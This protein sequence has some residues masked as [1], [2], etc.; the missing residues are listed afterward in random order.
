MSKE[1]SSSLW[2]SFCLVIECLFNP[3]W[4]AIL[5]P[6]KIQ[7]EEIL[8]RAMKYL[9]VAVSFTIGL[10][11]LLFFW[12]FEKKTGN[13]DLART[14]VFATVA[15]VSL[16]YVFSFRNLKKSVFN[17]EGF[18]ENKYLFY[19]VTYGFLLILIAVYVPF[20]NHL[21]KT[22]PLQLTHWLLV[23]AVAIM[24]TIWIEVVKY[25]ENRQKI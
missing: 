7:K 21:L 13:L 15:S 17:F 2:H 20:F 23:L 12:Y 11:S 6:Q 18:F 10:M 22:V 14:I 8:S 9:I 16:I 3:I 1:S 5:A 24:T 25:L 4:G 19:G